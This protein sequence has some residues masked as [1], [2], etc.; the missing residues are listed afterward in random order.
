MSKWKVYVR[1]FAPWWDPFDRCYTE[2][3]RFQGVA[4][5]DNEEDAI[6]IVMEKKNIAPF[7]V[8][9]CHSLQGKK[10]KRRDDADWWRAMRV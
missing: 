1:Y 3:W 9:I 8:R 7:E 2:K 5:A 6:K 4:Y 10:Y